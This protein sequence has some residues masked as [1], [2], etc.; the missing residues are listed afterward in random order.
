M[1]GQEVATSTIHRE[2]N[3]S[4]NNAKVTESATAAVVNT[5]RGSKRKQM[6][7]DKGKVLKSQMLGVQTAQIEGVLCSEGTVNDQG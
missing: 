2:D 6:Q 1:L 4:V 5:Q 3:P 7:N